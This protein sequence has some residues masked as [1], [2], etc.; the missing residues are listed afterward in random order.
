MNH[1]F[2]KMV[3]K[4]YTECRKVSDG[5]QISCDKCANYDDDSQK[6]GVTNDDSDDCCNGFMGYYD[7]PQIWSKCSIRDF[8]RSYRSNGWNQCM[9]T[10]TGNYIIR[11][12]CG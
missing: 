8:E 5:S 10:T 2:I 1:D 9:G 4:I 7:P 3:G 11:N 12:Q 6:I